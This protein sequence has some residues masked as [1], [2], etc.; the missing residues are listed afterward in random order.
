MSCLGLP[1]RR[2]GCI[3]VKIAGITKLVMMLEHGTC[4]KCLGAGFVW[5][6]KKKNLKPEDRMNG[7]D[8]TVSLLREHSPEAR[9]KLL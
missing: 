9:I 5:P 4:E 2:H 7:R 1:G 6:Q 3:G 8:S